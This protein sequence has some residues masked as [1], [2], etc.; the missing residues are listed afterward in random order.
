[1]PAPSV[2]RVHALR[3]LP[4]AAPPSPRPRLLVSLPFRWSKVFTRSPSSEVL[5]S[6]NLTL[7]GRSSICRLCK[8]S[9]GCELFLG[10]SGALTSLRPTLQQRHSSAASLSSQRPQQLH[11]QT[12]HAC[13][14]TAV[15]CMCA[16]RPRAMDPG[17]AI[18]AEVCRRAVPSAQCPWTP[19]R[20]A[21]ISPCADVRRSG[22]CLGQWQGLL[23]RTSAAEA[24]L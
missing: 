6:K 10:C 24:T 7:A 14:G 18:R 5:V 8:I 21:D 1:M 19:P 3:M 2:L 17:S 4:C 16:P 11:A 22:P 15:L 13:S 20:A 12:G 23:L 9:S